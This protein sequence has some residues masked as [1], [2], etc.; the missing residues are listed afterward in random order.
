MTPSGSKEAIKFKPR[1]VN[2]NSTS[3]LNNLTIK[4]YDKNNSLANLRLPS[5]N[6]KTE[7]QRK[8]R[9]HS[10]SGTNLGPTRDSYR[11]K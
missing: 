5:M 7:D 4:S 10:A 3:S 1:L 11:T 9:D 2:D 6:L 8:E